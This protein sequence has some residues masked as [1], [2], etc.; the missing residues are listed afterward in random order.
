M[1]V[2]AS[3]EAPMLGDVDW[4]NWRPAFQREVSKGCAMDAEPVSCFGFGVEE[5]VEV[6]SLV[7]LGCER[8]INEVSHP[9]VGRTC[10]SCP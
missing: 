8:G 9:P 7:V 3:V 2:H 5:A 4:L 1:D 6:V 10:S